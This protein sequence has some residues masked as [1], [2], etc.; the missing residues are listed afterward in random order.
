V[1]LQDQASTPTTPSTGYTRVYSK[2]DGLY[3]VDD[4][5][6]VTGPLIDLSGAVPGAFQAKT[7]ATG[8]ITVSSGPGAYTVACESG[9]TD[10]LDTITGTVEGDI[11]WVMADA[12]DTLSLDCSGAGNLVH[13]LQQTVIIWGQHVVGLIN[14]DGTNL[15]PFAFPRTRQPFYSNVDPTADLLDGNENT[16]ASITVPQDAMGLNG[17]I[18]IRFVLEYSSGSGNTI[19]IRTNFGATE[20]LNSNGASAMGSASYQVEFEII[21]V[22]AGAANSQ[23]GL[24]RG[25]GRQ[26]TDASI[27]EDWSDDGTAAID[28]SAGDTTVEVTF[29]HGNAT[30]TCYCRYF[31]AE[32]IRNT[33]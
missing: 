13:E 5:G 12:G 3:L 9:T 10:T 17:M 33:F 14:V 20:I 11:I 1:Q 32:L 6:A 4:A 24:L 18:R 31:E 8:A 23:V 19:T 16:I 26:F 27:T 30:G 29:Q 28:T 15:V 7:I 22:N 21:L 2:A 25:T